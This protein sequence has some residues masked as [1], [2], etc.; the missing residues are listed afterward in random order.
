M[1]YKDPEMARK[2]QREYNA[3]HK[4]QRAEYNKEYHRWWNA[5]H[6]EERR[7][8]SR[9]YHAAHRE[10]I[11]ARKAAYAK[12]HRAEYTQ[13]MREYRQRPGVRERIAASQRARYWKNREKWLKYLKNSYIRRREKCLDY[14][15][16]HR[17]ELN[18]RCAEDA[19]LYAA[20]R[21]KRRTSAAIKT[22]RKGNTYLPRFSRRIPDWAVKGQHLDTRS[23]FLA[24][25][26][27]ASQR[28]YARELA[29]ERKAAT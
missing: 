4:A 7:E 18:A 27:T 17:A 14:Q 15:R 13:R 29:I 6:R 8:Q 11:K 21:A 1:P 3:A 10:Q 2:H 19:V 28:A 22:M 9:K 25:N 24:V 23:A 26:L 16:R 5:A 20:I 12:A